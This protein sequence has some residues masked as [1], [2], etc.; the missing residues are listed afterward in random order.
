LTVARRYATL[1]NR[2]DPDSDI[3]LLEFFKPQTIN[4]AA[5]GRT[6]PLLGGR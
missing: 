4:A 5:A 2:V 1:H 3:G 6:Y